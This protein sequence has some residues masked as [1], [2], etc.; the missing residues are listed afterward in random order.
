MPVRKKIGELLVEAGAVSEQ[1]VREALGHQKSW[2]AARKLGDMLIATRNV[3][4]KA[5]A[6]ALAQQFD[7][8]FVELPEIPPEVA[9][10]VPPEPMIWPAA[11]AASGR[12]TT[13][14]SRRSAPTARPRVPAGSSH[15]AVLTLTSKDSISDSPRRTGL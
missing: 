5:V 7:L 15:R 1:D 12:S 6:R 2:G 10:A 4:Y 3:T 9:A 13:L 8:P 11:L 14:S